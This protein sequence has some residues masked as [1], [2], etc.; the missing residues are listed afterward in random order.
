VARTSPYC[1]SHTR[2]RF[3]AFKKQLLRT[4]ARGEEAPQKEACSQEEGCQEA[5]GQEGTYG[6]TGCVPAYLVVADPFLPLSHVGFDAQTTA[7]KKT[8]AKKATKPKAKTA[9]KT[10][11]TTA[12]KV[13]DEVSIC[14]LGVGL[15]LA[16]VPTLSMNTTYQN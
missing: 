13:S 8:S 12:K 1:I 4:I 3:T 14:S 15:D 16:A 5:G 11:K 7:T 9:T 6:V 2:S 10:K